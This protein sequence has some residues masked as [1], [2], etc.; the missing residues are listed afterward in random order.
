MSIQA[1]AL[2]V[3]LVINTAWRK[4]IIFH[5]LGVLAST[6]PLISFV[7]ASQSSQQM[8]RLNQLSLLAGML[9]L[10]YLSERLG[11]EWF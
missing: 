6:L 10:T 9:E 3:P 2:L 1:F 11:N 7:R 4:L 5:H 8:A